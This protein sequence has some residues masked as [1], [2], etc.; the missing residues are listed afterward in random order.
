MAVRAHYQTGY[1]DESTKFCEMRVLVYSTLKTVG[2]S[3]QGAGR[4]APPCR[5]RSGAKITREA[6]FMTCHAVIDDVL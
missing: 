4:T 3:V 5:I 2:M 6:Y 1:T